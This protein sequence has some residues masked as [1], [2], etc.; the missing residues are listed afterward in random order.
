MNLDP[1]SC[2]NWLSPTISSMI[3]LRE[4]YRKK[5]DMSG[6]SFHGLFTAFS[7][8]FTG[9]SRPFHTFSPARFFA[10]SVAN[11]QISKLCHRYTSEILPKKEYYEHFPYNYNDKP[12]V[13]SIG[14]LRI[15]YTTYKFIY[16]FGWTDSGKCSMSNWIFYLKGKAGSYFPKSICSWRNFRTGSRSACFHWNGA[17]AFFPPWQNR[18]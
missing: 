15:S 6:P 4:K 5:C 18:R 9:F 13:R 7:H 1:I 14:Y 3:F 17:F 12:G 2:M 11:Y 16:F 10:G 8:I